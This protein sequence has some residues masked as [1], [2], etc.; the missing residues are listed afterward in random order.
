M[1]YAILFSEFQSRNQQNSSDALL[2]IVIA[3]YAFGLIQ[4]MCEVG[5]RL[6]NSFI[7]IYNLIEQFSWYKYPNRIQRHLI[8]ILVVAQ[9]PVNLICFGSN[10]CDR[11]TFKR[12]SL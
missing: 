7:E 12:V 11:D 5:H 10:S 9:K 1:L 8:I 2:T 6:R 3:G 4:N